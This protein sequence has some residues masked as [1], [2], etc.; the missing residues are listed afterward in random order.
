MKKGTDSSDRQH[1]TMT[2][3]YIKNTDGDFVCPDCGVIKK[4]QNSMHY[5]MKKHMEELNY[6]CK[7]CNKGFLQ[8][9]TLDLHIRSKHPELCKTNDE[10]DEK[11]FSCPFDDCS[12]KALTKGNCIIHCLRLHFQDEM[13]KIMEVNNEV[14]TI[15]CNECNHEF[16][17]SS[18]FYY[19]C[20]GCMTF[21]KTDSKFKTFQAF[22]VQ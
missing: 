14:K 6:V 8:K 22:L 16:H 11:K 4:R 5:H 10:E 7:A 20:K 15:L 18:A 2:I 12:F 19:H 3:K 21:D 1:S 9:Q 13:K 17:S